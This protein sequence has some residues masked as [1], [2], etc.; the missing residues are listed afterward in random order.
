LIE[1]SRLSHHALMAMW[2]IM[3]VVSLGPQ[4]SEGSVAPAKGFSRRAVLFLRE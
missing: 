4:R 2:I 1:F 3:A